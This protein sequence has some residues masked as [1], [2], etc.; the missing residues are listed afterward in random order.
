MTLVQLN[1]L[2]IVAPFRGS[3]ICITIAEYRSADAKQFAHW[4]RLPAQVSKHM[5][6]GRLQTFYGWRRVSYDCS[7]DLK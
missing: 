7:K 1:C 5:D 2:L 6:F 4:V 3:N